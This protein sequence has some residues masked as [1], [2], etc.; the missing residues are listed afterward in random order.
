VVVDVDDLTPEQ[1]VDRVLSD[2]AVASAGAGRV[3]RR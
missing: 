3:G 1:V 2:P